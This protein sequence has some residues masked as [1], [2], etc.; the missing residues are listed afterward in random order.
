MFY[1]PSTGPQPMHEP[2]HITKCPDYDPTHLREQIEEHLD[3]YEKFGDLTGKKVLLKIN[4][5]SAHE[6]ERAITT[7]PEVSRKSLKNW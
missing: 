5:L 1:N 6:P 3:R 2:I 7:H 4:L